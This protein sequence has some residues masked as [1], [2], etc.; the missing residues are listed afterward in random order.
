M[1]SDNR[2]S[3]VTLSEK[4]GI[5]QKS[6]WL[7]M[8]KLRYTMKIDDIR[9]TGIIAIDEVYIGGCLT[10]FH[11]GRKI[12]LLREQNLMSEKDKRYTK[13]ALFALNSRIKSPVLGMIDNKHLVLIQ[14]PNPTKQSDIRNLFKKHVEGDSIAI[15]DESKLYDDWTLSELHTNNHHNNKYVSKEGYSSNKIENAFSW[16]KRGFTSRITHCDKGYLQ[17]YLNEFCFRHNNK[18]VNFTCI[19]TSILSGGT[20]THRGLI[21]SRERI[22]SAY[23]MKKTRHIYTLS[24]IKEFFTQNPYLNTIK[25]GKQIYRREDF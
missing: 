1:L 20:I 18:D 5:N 2:I 10:N 7:M 8:M 24:E 13:S 22:R 11:Y 16:L 21:D 25:F 4:L 15:S 9:L 19:L 12:R 3:S 23:K 14:L 17:L 6:A